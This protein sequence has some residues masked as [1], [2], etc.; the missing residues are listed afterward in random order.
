M[1]TKL[2]PRED[3]KTPVSFCVFIYCSPLVANTPIQLTTKLFTDETQV[4]TKS[5]VNCINTQCN[6]KRLLYNGY[7]LCPYTHFKVRDQRADALYKWAQFYVLSGHVIEQR[8]HLTQ[9]I[10]TNT[11]LLKWEL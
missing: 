3:K 2:C 1:G 7:H 6:N 8:S 10:K 9:K 4:Q 11:H 5:K